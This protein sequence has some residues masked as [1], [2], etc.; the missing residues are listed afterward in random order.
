VALD[1]VTGEVELGGDLGEAAR[2][3]HQRQHP[4]LGRAWATAEQRLLRLAETPWRLVID[5]A[6]RRA[7]AYRAGRRVR[8]W[9]IV[10][11]KP[12]TPTPRGLYAVYERVRQPGGSE[13]GPFVL[14]LTAHSDAL[15]NF[16]GGPG[17]VAL[18]GRSGPLLYDPLGSASSHGCIRMQNPIIRWLAAR[19]RPGTPVEI[20]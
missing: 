2:A 15:Q 7:S 8:S 17:R 18:H 19:A 6:A 3:G 5:R 12:G 9:R 1:R 14:H 4:Q 16:G 13:L 10:V 11:G 20:R